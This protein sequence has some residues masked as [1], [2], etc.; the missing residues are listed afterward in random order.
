MGKAKL[1]TRE[2]IL[3]RMWKLA[4]SK[5]ADA[6]RLACAPQEEW[7]DVKRLEL[8]CLTEFKRGSNGVV[9]LRFVDRGRLLERLLDGVDQSGEEQ[10]DRF[11][12]AMEE[13]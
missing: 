4:N 12:Q 9:E 3:G 1:P 11:L 5:A 2:D 8:D 6:V 10:V 7:G 13:G